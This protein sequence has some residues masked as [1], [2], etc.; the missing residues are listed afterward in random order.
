M[1]VLYLEILCIIRKMYLSPYTSVINA[2]HDCINHRG[3]RM[4]SLPVAECV[5]IE[6]CAN[7]HNEREDNYYRA[8]DAIYEDYRVI[9]KLF[10]YFIHEPCQAVPP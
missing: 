4:E 2:S 3:I 6:H 9:R 10:P 8:Y 1:I 5:E 7:K